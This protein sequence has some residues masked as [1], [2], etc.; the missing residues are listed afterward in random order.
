MATTK[1]AGKPLFCRKAWLGYV[2]NVKQISEH[3][4][5]LRFFLLCHLRRCCCHIINQIIITTR[6]SSHGAGVTGDAPSGVSRLSLHSKTRTGGAESWDKTKPRPLKKS[7]KIF[8][9]FLAMRIYG[10]RSIG[11]IMDTDCAQ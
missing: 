6:K 2:R 4:K 10:S 3:S 8:F 11:C 9:Y 7:F 1:T 5:N